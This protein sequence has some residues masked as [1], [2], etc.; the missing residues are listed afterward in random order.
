[1]NHPRMTSS[2]RRIAFFLGLAIAFALP[3]RVECGYAGA[4]A[5][6]HPGS[7]PRETCIDYKVEPWGFYLLESVFSRNVGFA[8]SSGEDCR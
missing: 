1:M 2:G 3:K 8:Y 7:R 4:T 5:C 6:A